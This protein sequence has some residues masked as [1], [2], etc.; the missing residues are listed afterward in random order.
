[1]DEEIEE[2]IR[3]EINFWL[4]ANMEVF[5]EILEEWE[6]NNYVQ[7]YPNAKAHF[8]C[9][10]CAKCCNFNLS[11]HWVWV[12][13][14][15]MVKWMQKLEEEDYI[16]LFLSALFP[17]EDLDGISGYGLPSQKEISLRYEE[18]IRENKK[19]PIIQK[20]LKAVLQALNQLNPD[21]DP[22]SDYCIYYTPNP[23]ENSGHCLIYEHRP[24]QCRAYP[25]D[26]PQFTKFNIPGFNEENQDEELPLCPEATY[27]GG[28][29]KDGVAV[30]DD[31]LENV[32]VEKANYKTSAVIFEWSQKSDDWK[33]IKDI[34]LCDLFLQ[35]F[36]KDILALVRKSKKIE[37]NKKKS[38]KYIAGKR[39]N[40]KKK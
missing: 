37:D 29:A 38:T 9:N 10:D 40:R 33:K 34:D 3:E 25:H 8:K 36:H 31:E 21:F 15:D 1:M 23:K 27:S 18:L 22:N 16:P 19:F 14:Y 11:D 17:V 7:P 20:T 6:N 28:A 2:E 32:I 12:Y 39:P 4:D 26:Y 13:P 30:S 35:Y 24:I 5:G